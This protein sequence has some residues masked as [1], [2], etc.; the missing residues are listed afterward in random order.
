MRRSGVHGKGVFALQDLVAGTRLIEYRGERIS[1]EEAQRRHP[2]HPQDPNHTLYFHLDDGQVIDAN[3][4]G[5]SARWIN[6]AC[7]PNCEVQEERGRIFIHALRDIHAGEELHYDYGLVVEER[8]TA[9]LRA[10]YPCHC[11]APACRGTLLAPKRR[12]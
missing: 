2:Q 10:E 1:W 8:Y 11:G 12:R 6:H 4:G 7:A 9:K 3:H 5:N